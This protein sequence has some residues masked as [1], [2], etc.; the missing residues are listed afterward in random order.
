[1]RLCRIGF[2]IAL[3]ALSA[4]GCQPT[5]SAPHEIVG[6]RFDGAAHNRRAGRGDGAR[7]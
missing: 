5:T 6:G 2:A 4:S 3:A 7:P 1:M